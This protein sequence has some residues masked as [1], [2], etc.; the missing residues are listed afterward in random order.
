MLDIATDRL[1]EEGI[2][3]VQLRG[4]LDAITAREFQ[5]FFDEVLKSGHRFIVARAGLLDYVSSAGIAALLGLARRLGASGGALAFAE[6]NP[7]VRL[8][9]QFFGL[10]QV[11]LQ[12]DSLDAA[13]AH[14]TSAIQAGSFALELER[15]RVIRTRVGEA[16]KAPAAQLRPAAET[17][18]AAARRVDDNRRAELR[19]ARRTSAVQVRRGARREAPAAESADAPGALDGDEIP[20]ASAQP[21]PDGEAFDSKAVTPQAPAGE[22][23]RSGRA[24]GSARIRESF[25]EIHRPDRAKRLPTQAGGARSD[26]EGDVRSDEGRAQRGV[27]FS[28]R[29]APASKSGFE[30]PRV[31]ACEQCGASLRVYRAGLYLCPECA[32]EFQISRDGGASFFEKL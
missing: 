5:T 31:L 19:T 23:D 22:V 26:F 2:L 4:R 16:S 8:L 11:L 13:R 24:A 29:E 21:V 28:V 15:E 30:Q 32:V 25:Q 7:E 20:T 1:N 14:F 18:G 9:L 12:F 6:L 3:V 10:E 27:R 17:Q